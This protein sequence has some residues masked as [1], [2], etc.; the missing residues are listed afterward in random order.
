M[1]ILDKHRKW[2]S[3][4]LSEEEIIN[5]GLYKAGELFSSS[6]LVYRDLL[7]A[8]IKDKNHILANFMISFPDNQRLMS[9]QNGIFIGDAKLEKFKTD[10]Q[11]TYFES[12]V[13]VTITS[14]AKNPF[15]CKIQLDMGYYAVWEIIRAN[16]DFASPTI[17]SSEYVHTIRGMSSGAKIFRDNIRA[18]QCT[19]TFR[20][21][22]SN[23]LENPFS[24]PEKIWGEDLYVR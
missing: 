5:L 24:N 22:S 21:A 16:Q 10:T 18:R 11:S 3:D 7:R 8:K 20:E 2:F 14:K 6:Y 12:D 13:T 9:Y 4:D 15:I 19:F 17:K 1:N 23:R